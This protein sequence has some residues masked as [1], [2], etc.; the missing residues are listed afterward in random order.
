M[1]FQAISILL[2]QCNYA[3]S[4]QESYLSILKSFKNYCQFNGIDS[5]KDAVPYLMH[6]ID[7]NKSVS[8]QNQ[9]IN[10]IKFYWER[11]LGKQKEYLSIDR[12]MKERK[13]PTVLSLEEVNQIITSIHNL[14]HKMI[15]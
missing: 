11:V 7:E 3:P 14:K 12:P 9:A 10:A 15:L 8:T 2:K 6:L 4:T 1:D 5:N 13:L